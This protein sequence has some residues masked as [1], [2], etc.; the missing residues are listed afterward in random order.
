MGALDRIVRAILAFIIGILY[1]SGQ[2]SGTVALI[3]GIIAIVLL[4]TGLIGFCPMYVPLK[5]CTLKTKHEEPPASSG[6]N[7][8]QSA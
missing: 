5:I 1:F 3:L 2:I 4:A 8:T 6:S 7:H